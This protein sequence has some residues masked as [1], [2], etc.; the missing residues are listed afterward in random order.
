M[1]VLRFLFFCYIITSFITR[2]LFGE[3]S[4]LSRFVLADF[5]GLAALIVFILQHGKFKASVPYQMAWLLVAGFFIGITGSDFPITSFNEVIILLFLIAVS[6]SI[7]SIYTEQ[8]NILLLFIALAW[9]NLIASTIGIYD[10]YF[11]SFGLPRIFKARADG[12][13]LSGFRNAGQAGAFMQITLFMMYAFSRTELKN[14]FS[15]NNKLLLRISL[16][17]G[18]VFFVLTGKVAAYIGG[19]VG[20][21]LYLIMKRRL[22]SFFTVLLLLAGLVWLFNELP[23]IAPQINKRIFAKVRTR[24]LEPMEISDSRSKVN[25]TAFINRNF[26]SALTAFYDNPL[27]GSGI[28]GFMGRYERHEV[29]STYLKIIGETGLLGIIPY[30]LLMYFMLRMLFSKRIMVDE[31]NDI[32]PWFAFLMELRPFVIGWL[33]SWGYTY[34]LRKRE[35]WIAFAIISIV[36]KLIIDSKNKKIL[37]RLSNEQT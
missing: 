8:K 35:F 14:R 30:L 29:H 31:S 37:N 18:F 9:V 36:Y 33:I 7:F 10:S 13:A 27:T 24:I 16:I 3:G 19:S 23:T 2:P 17:V 1:K 34:H 4:V 21:L 6:Q 32:H 25:G 26:E 22:S 28:G 5:F 20:I 11:T 15:V 12:E